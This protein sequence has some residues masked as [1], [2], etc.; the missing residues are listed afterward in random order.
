M[1]RIFLR[2]QKSH[3]YPPINAQMNRYGDK[4]NVDFEPKN[5]IFPPFLGMIRIFLQNPKLSL[6]HFLMHV[7]K[8][9]DKTWRTDLEKGSKVKILGLKM[10][11]LGRNKNFPQKTE[12][13]T[14]P[15]NLEKMVL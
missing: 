2:I 8:Y 4:L 15:V 7:I 6:N 5:Y 11:H 9:F 1:I 14:F 10:T 13:V 12:S 3:F